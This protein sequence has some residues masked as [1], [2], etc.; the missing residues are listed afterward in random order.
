MLEVPTS[1]PVPARAEAA[2]A[3]HAQVRA[4][5]VHWRCASATRRLLALLERDAPGL[6]VLVVANGSGDGSDEALDA[7][8]TGRPDRGVLIQPENRG[9]GAGCNAGIRTVLAEPGVTHVLLLNPDV[10]TTPGFVDELLAT[11][12]GHPD[13]AIVGARILSMDGARVLF[14]NGRIRPL[15]LTRC[16]VP[17]PAAV[18]DW[19]TAFVSGACMLIDAAALRAGL[20]FDERYFL[21]VEDLDLCRQVAARG[22]TCRVTRR[23]VVHHQD[24][25]TQRDDVAF[26]G[27]MRATQIYHLA[28]GKMMF[29]KKW[30][31]PVQRAVFVFVAAVVKP[32]VGLFVWRSVA[33]VRMHLRGVRDGLRAA[34]TMERDQP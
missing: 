1:S 24:G 27:G 18:D 22:Q 32:L 31:G 28:R 21:Y 30:L 5:V 14:E 17:G 9:F 19:P 12:A 11:A 15:T 6:R 13:A 20:A 3:R 26:A 33:P 29:A 2:P 23:A 16:Q 8:L 10:E 4:V 25:G 7:E 34:R